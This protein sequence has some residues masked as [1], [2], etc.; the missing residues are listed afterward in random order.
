MKPRT[1]IPWLRDRRTPLM[2]G[3]RLRVQLH[4]AW[5]NVSVGEHTSPVTVHG[6]R[7]RLPSSAVPCLPSEVSRK[8]TRLKVWFEHVKSTIYVGS[9]SDRGIVDKGTLVNVG[10]YGL[11]WIIWLMYGWDSYLK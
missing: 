4:G 9:S 1:K 5:G 6:V 3:Y 8:R 7:R 11:D 10:P 2:R